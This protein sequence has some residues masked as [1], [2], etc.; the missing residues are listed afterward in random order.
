MQSEGRQESKN[1]SR[2]FPRL[3]PSAIPYSP[4]GFDE[5]I[6]YDSWMYLEAWNNSAEVFSTAVLIKENEII[7][8]IL[9][10]IPTVETEG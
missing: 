8:Q 1:L 9:L 6:P 5:F 10:K 4:L 2:L 7:K 3:S